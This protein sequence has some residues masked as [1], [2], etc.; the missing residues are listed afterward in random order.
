MREYTQIWKRNG[1]GTEP[2]CGCGWGGGVAVGNTIAVGSAREPRN[3][4][5]D[6]VAPFL[7]PWTFESD[8]AVGS[9]DSGGHADDAGQHGPLVLA[10]SPLFHAVLAIH[11]P[12]KEHKSSMN[13]HRRHSTA[14]VIKDN[15]IACAQHRGGARTL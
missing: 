3:W 8:V 6:F 7:H 10:L 2:R 11:S 14:T 12:P 4:A 1:T 13:L 15:R 5:L 9:K